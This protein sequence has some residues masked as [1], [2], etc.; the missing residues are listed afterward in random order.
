MQYP[1]T[2]QLHSK[3]RQKDIV[4]D[5]MRELGAGPQSVN[6]YRGGYL[7]LFLKKTVF[8]LFIDGFLLS[9]HRTIAKNDKNRETIKCM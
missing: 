6:R 7:Y 1:L 4:R 8:C 3:D 5:V 9:L 2:F